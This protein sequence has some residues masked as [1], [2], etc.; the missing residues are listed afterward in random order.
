MLTRIYSVITV[1]FYKGKKKNQSELLKKTH[2]IIM[3]ISTFIM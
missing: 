2:T 3:V 1:V